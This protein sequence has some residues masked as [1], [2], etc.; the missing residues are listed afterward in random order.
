MDNLIGKKL[1]DKVE[2]QVP[3]GMMEFEIMDI[4]I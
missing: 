4:S 2:V 3:A 1:G